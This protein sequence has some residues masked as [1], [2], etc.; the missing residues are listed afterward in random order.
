MKI[1]VTGGTGFVGCHVLR[2]ALARGWE[3]VGHRRSE[4]SLPRVPLE[5]HP[6]WVTKPLDEIVGNDLKDCQV[7]I[8]LAAHTPNPPYDTFERCFYW[9]VTTAL[10]LVDQARQAGVTRFIVAGSCFEYGKAGERYERIPPDAPLEP[11][12]SYPASKAAAS[13]ALYAWAIHHKVELWIGRIF[14]VYGPGEPETRLWPS[15]RRA[16][17]AGEDFP[18][19]AGEQVR[20]FVPVEM[21]AGKFIE[22]VA[23][24]DLSPGEPQIENVGSGRAQTLREFAEHWWNHWGAKGQL[25]FGALPYRPGEVM[26]FVPLL[27]RTGSAVRFAQKKEADRIPQS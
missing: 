16:A 20:D 8:H 14:Q 7:L 21:V 23:R 24:T 18:M 1:F 11:V 25:Q 12:T 3:V 17:L 10:R 19:T 5:Q 27:G 13:V 4:V 15:L 22:A 26:R 6:Q 2:E 9:N